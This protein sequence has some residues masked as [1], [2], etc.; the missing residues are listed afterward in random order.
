MNNDQETI[1]E[2]LP[3]L[4]P[5]ARFID[6]IQQFLLLR[7]WTQ[8]QLAKAAGVS[9]TALS[10]FISGKYNGDNEKM[11]R[12]IADAIET[13]T[14]HITFKTTNP[15]FIETFNS[16]RFF[17]IAHNCLMSRDIAVCYG[18]A[19]FGKTESAREYVAQKPTAIL[20]EADPGYTP[21]V[22]F[23]ELHTKI[24]GAG[25]HTLHNLFTDCID[26]LCNSN[27]L[28]IIDEAEQLPYKSL[29]MM[30]RLWDK[31]NIGILLVG[32]P[33]LIGNL[34]GIRGQFSQ[35]Y[36]RVG[37]VA[38]LEP[39]REEDSEN[40]VKRQIGDTDGLWR[41][42]HRECNG[43]HRRL[44]KLIRNAILIQDKFNLPAINTEVVSQA[45]A[46]IIEAR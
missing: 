29:E 46:M 45:K 18:D 10:Q 19:G 1:F 6:K 13:E 23:R 24:G 28:L 17:M 20:I 39:I 9:R 4:S 15:D 5:R 2:E 14:A 27:R 12:L 8:H 16:K 44:F 3:H 43:S 22:L 32:M 31:A 36:S 26:R 34:R 37:F 41:V 33:K 25:N 30:R 40:I 11:Q 7:S 38:R 42:F 21:T 35:L